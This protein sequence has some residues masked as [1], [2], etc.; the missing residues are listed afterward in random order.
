[1]ALG[2]GWSESSPVE[3]LVLRAAQLVPG[4]LNC[5]DVAVGVSQALGSPSPTDL[6]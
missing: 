5:S 2:A 4:N 1:M 6:Q 3:V